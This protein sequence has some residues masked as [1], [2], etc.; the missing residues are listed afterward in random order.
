MLTKAQDAWNKIALLAIMDASLRVG[1]D[2]LDN[3]EIQK[4]AFLTELA[5]NFKNLNTAYFKFYRDKHG[6]YSKGVANT[7]TS[8]EQL[9]MVRQENREILDRGRYLLRYVRPEVEKSESALAAFGL[10]GEVAREWKNYRGWSIKLKVYELDI[11]VQGMGGRILKMPDIPL[12]TDILDPETS[13]KR[14]T[15]PFSPEMVDDICAELAI[16]NARLDAASEDVWNHS[17][18]ALTAAF[19]R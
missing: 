17:L 15:L 5:G 3:V 6:P 10:I 14:D 7:V 4:L 16:P 8:F 11:P 13:G 9:G 1:R 18:D 19:A 12:Y 2:S